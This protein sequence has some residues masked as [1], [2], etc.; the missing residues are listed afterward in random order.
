MCLSMMLNMSEIWQSHLVV[1][2][3]I[4]M[5]QEYYAHYEWGLAASSG[6]Q[7]GNRNMRQ[8]V[9]LIMSEVWHGHLVV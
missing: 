4:K 3:E 2:T 1:K 9:T 6:G 5:C 7:N 8:S